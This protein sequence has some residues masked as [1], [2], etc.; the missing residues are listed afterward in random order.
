MRGKLLV[1]GLLGTLL[2]VMAPAAVQAEENY[3]GDE[4]QPQEMCPTPEGPYLQPVLRK[5]QYGLNVEFLQSE[6]GIWPDGCFGPATDSAVRAFQRANDLYEDGIVGT[7]T[8]HVLTE[9]TRKSGCR[10]YQGVSEES[11][12]SDPDSTSTTPAQ[13]SGEHY[14]IVDQSDNYTYAMIGDS[15][16]R[17]MPMVDNPDKLPTGNYQVINQLRINHDT[18]LNWVLRYFTR[19]HG[20]IGFHAVPIDAEDGWAMHLNELL[21]TNRAVSAGCIRLSLED[22]QYLYDFASSGMDIVVR[23]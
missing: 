9:G 20:G 21:G 15:I 11:S 19:I 22:A 3:P 8:W 16:V 7:C 12:T 23:H 6:L 2:T 13:P 4:I 14:I 10:S 5:G 18:S 1:V 17:S